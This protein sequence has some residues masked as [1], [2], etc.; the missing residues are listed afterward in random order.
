MDSFEAK[1]IPGTE[2]AN[3][4][5][6]SPDSQW[7][8]FFAESKLRKVSI[9][10]GAAVTLAGIP[11]T[12]QLSSPSWGSDDTI[13]FQAF[14]FGGLLRVSAAGGTPQLLIAPD[15]K[16]GEIGAGGPAFL[17]GAKAVLFTSLVG[18][19]VGP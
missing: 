3:A 4:P 12:S 8:G 14:V 1:A 10:G 18:A 5:F 11:T 9:A 15:S 19:A 2:G 6:F 13:I 7:V 16:K 17:P